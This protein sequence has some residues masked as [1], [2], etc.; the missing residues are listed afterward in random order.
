[1]V[2][3]LAG[4]LLA[5]TAACFQYVPVDEVPAR[6]T[7]VRV[8][9]ARQVPIELTEIT[10]TNVEEV[11]GEVVSGDDGRLVLSVLGVRLLGGVDYLARGETVVLP[12]DAV[13]S[14]TAK[15]FSPLRTAL[16]TAVLAGAGFLVERA[17]SAAIG[18]GEGGGPGGEPR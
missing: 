4:V 10:A 3:A 9:L 18:G 14:L 16:A 6:G 15:R 7:P 8:G 5:S 17:L 11:R 12:Q 13:A 1:M 2:R